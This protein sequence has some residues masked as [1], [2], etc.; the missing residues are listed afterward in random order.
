MIRGEV[1]NVL[2]LLPFITYC[3]SQGVA[4]AAHLMFDDG[5]L[6]MAERLK[7]RKEK[8]EQINALKVKKAQ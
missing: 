5:N 8:Q 4:V 7:I 3:L 1:F 2:V 6:T